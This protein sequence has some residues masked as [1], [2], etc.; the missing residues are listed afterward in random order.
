[1]IATTLVGRDQ[2]HLN[3]PW[4]SARTI[5]VDSTEVGVLEFGITDAETQGLYQGGSP[6]TGAIS[7][8]KDRCRDGVFGG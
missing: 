8:T 6:K 3:Q 4:V 7:V 1:M 2:A 5:R